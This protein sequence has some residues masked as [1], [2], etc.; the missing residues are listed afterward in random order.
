M[1]KLFIFLLHPRY[2]SI[3][4]WIQ[5]L[6]P[7]NA[8]DTDTNVSTLYLFMKPVR[9][10]MQVGSLDIRFRFIESDPYLK[11]SPNRDNIS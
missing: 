5:L 7:S 1:Y 9:W 11:Q 4:D 2:S 10:W 6:S 3:C 8:S